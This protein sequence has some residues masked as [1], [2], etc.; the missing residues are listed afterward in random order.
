MKNVDRILNKELTDWID[1]IF[2]GAVTGVF[3]ILPL[4]IMMTK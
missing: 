2:L 3:L 4:L 1:L